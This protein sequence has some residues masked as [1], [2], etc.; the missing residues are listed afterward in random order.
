M[1]GGRNW[2]WEAPLLHKG[3]KERDVRTEVIAIT[4]LVMSSVLVGC[5]NPLSSVDPTA[6]ATSVPATVAP[7]DS[8]GPDVPQE[9]PTA[10]NTPRPKPTKTPERYVTIDGTIEDGSKKPAVNLWDNYQTRNR[11]VTSAPHGAKV[12]LIKRQG[13]GVLVEHK[14]KQGWCTDW[15]IREFK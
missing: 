14:G 3:E 13:D 6:T 15:F 2:R 12:K 7:T 10:T 9:A 5:A 1:P 8:A 11:V 4:L